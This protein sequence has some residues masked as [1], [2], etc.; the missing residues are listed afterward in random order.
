MCREI[1]VCENACGSCVLVH[2]LLPSCETVL[3]LLLSSNV[4]VG[5]CRGNLFM[6]FLYV[7]LEHVSWKR[8][9]VGL[10]IAI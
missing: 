10:L 5:L 8:N 7:L 1:L 9:N 4:L 6:S 2:E 3:G